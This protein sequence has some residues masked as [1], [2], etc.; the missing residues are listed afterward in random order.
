M[1]SGYVGVLVLFLA[2]VVELRGAQVARLD[3]RSPG[4]HRRTI[5]GLDVFPLLAAHGEDVA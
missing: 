5:A 2:D 1:F 4:N 3:F